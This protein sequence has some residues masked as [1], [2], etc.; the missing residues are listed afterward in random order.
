MRR[1]DFDVARAGGFAAGLVLAGAIGKGD[2][3]SYYYDVTYGARSNRVDGR[4]LA[5][6]S[7]TLS[8]GA[9]SARVQAAAGAVWS[10]IFKDEDDGIYARN[11]A[12]M[13]LEASVLVGYHVS[14]EWSVGVA[15][16][17]TA[18]GNATWRDDPEASLG[19]GDVGVLLELRKG[20]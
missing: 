1:L 7:W 8:H 15:P 10:H 4:A 11:W 20:P 18:Y 16:V 6:I 5:G 19:G 12:G 9:W 13:L 17:V 3:M 2:S 14:D